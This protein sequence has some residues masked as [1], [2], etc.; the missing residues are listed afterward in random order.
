MKQYF[1]Q[2]LLLVLFTSIGATAVAQAD[3]F[4]DIHVQVQK[5]DGAYVIDATF[6][7]PAT[8]HESWSVLTDYGHMAQFISNV[9]SSQ[10]ISRYGSSMKV[11]QQGEASR[12]PIKFSFDSIREI[13]MKPYT[14]IRSTLIRGNMKKMDGLTLVS[15]EANGTR[16]VY[17]GESIP[18]VWAPAGIA[19]D[20]I[21]TEI[22]Q[23]FGEMRREILRRKDATK[24]R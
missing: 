14:E 3:S 20:F 5:R 9:K 15:A 13:T 8:V 4:N 6:F 21:K 2:F 17:H 12:W 18:D 7:V 16:I 24:E 19:S 22:Q 10:I 1:V 23:Q 11:A